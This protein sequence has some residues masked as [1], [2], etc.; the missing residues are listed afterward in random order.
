MAFQLAQ[1]YG[2]V[3]ELLAIF[4]NGG[5]NQVQQVDPRIDA[6]ER[7]L[8]AKER[9]EEE[10]STNAARMQIESFANETDAT[11]MLTHPYFDNVKEL[12]GALLQSGVHSDLQSAYDAAIK[13]HPDTHALQATLNGEQ[14]QA[15][16]K[17]RAQRAEK[18]NKA[19]P[20]KK[21]KHV[22]E[23]PA[24]PTGSVD[25]TMREIYNS[26]AS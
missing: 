2:F 6:L 25:D 19:T 1:K 3:N 18:A 5:Q 24:K 20:P 21:G 16:A 9:E 13:A 22:P 12:M 10:S 15:D 26:I 8:A 7:K 11:G 17:E 4:R 23:K 14:R